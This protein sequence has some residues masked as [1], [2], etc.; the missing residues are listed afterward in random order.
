MSLV[1]GPMIGL[2]LLGILVA[3]VFGRRRSTKEE[4]PA[5]GDAE[6]ADEDEPQDDVR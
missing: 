1:A 5:A 4:E 3:L 2:Y 6:D